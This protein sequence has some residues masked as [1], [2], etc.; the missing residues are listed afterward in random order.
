MKHLALAIYLPAL[1][2]A[3]EP[4]AA[5]P[6]PAA[7]AQIPQDP[8]VFR[9][10]VRK[11]GDDGVHSYRIPGLATSTKGTVLAVFDMRHVSS[12]DLPGDI[13]VGLM[14]S[15]DNGT[16]WEPVRKVLDF[17]KTEAGSAGNGVGD[18]AI[19]VDAKTGTI[20]VAA[21]WSKGNRAWM[22][23]QAGM[24]PEETGQFVITK[25]T[26]DGLTWSAPVSI[27]SQVK[28]PIWRL[29]FNG[30]GNGIQLHDGTLVF[31]AQFR[32]GGG[33]PHSCFVY[34]KDSGTSWRISTAPL[35][36]QPPTSEAA[37][38][39]CADGS[40]LLSMRNESRSGQ[41]AW[42]RWSWKGDLSQ[43]RWS[44]PWF[45]L[46]DPTCMASLISHPKGTLL[47][48]NPA[49]TQKREKMTIRSSTDNGA[50][51]NAGQ[52]GRAHV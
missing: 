24:K 1:L 7:A 21:L 47:Y 20:F 6:T 3:A 35:P 32:H 25:S 43:G 18:P 39:Q 33:T 10:V 5:T 50:T 8:K 27:T 46:A 37:I 40:L 42:S 30:P 16:T 28:D 38:A 51:W 44:I 23:S 36:E 22:G 4:E 31:A 2:L 14:R 9:T 52:I 17:D 41:R 11:L 45:D 48:S 34:S 49:D 12:A 26:D 15:I 29:C 19:L 13:D